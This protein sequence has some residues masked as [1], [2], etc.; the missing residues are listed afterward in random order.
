MVIVTV[1]A[2]LVNLSAALAPVPV[3]DP[4][5][6]ATVNV[7]FIVSV[8]LVIVPVLVLFPAKSVTSPIT[9]TFGVSLDAIF[10]GKVKYT[11]VLLSNATPA[12]VVP[13]VPTSAERGTSVTPASVVT[14]NADAVVADNS[15]L[16][17]TTNLSRESDF[18]V[19][20][21]ESQYLPVDEVPIT[22]FFSSMFIE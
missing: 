8:A 3:P 12:A 21:A 13:L 11:L 5:V 18:S 17:V 7:G 6:T 9:F 4:P 10:E 19:K 22:G 14:W 1:I 2:D 20:D 16:N 15:S